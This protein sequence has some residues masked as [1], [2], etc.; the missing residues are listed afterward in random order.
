MYIN[1]LRE[2][3]LGW[4]LVSF[5]LSSNTIDRDK[6]SINSSKLYDNNKKDESEDKPNTNRKKITNDNNGDLDKKL[7]ADIESLVV[8]KNINQDGKAGI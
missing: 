2:I 4:P 6:P 8:E 3:C 1:F 5:F 7:S